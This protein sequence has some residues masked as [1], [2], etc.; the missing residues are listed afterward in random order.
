MEQGKAPIGTDGEPVNLH[1]LT[2]TEPGSIAEVGGAFHSEKTKTLHIPQYE[3][4]GGKWVPRKNY[5]FRKP[6]G[7]KRDWPLTKGGKV[8]KT[9]VEKAFERWSSLYWKDRAKGF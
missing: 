4:I 7:R 5:S 9:E 1:H 8:A 2:G 3:K 6:D